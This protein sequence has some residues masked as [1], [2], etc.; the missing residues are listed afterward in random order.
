MAQQKS[1]R[2]VIDDLRG[3]QNSYDPPT[4]L[5]DNECVGANNV[6]WRGGKSL[7]KKRAGSAVSGFTAGHGTVP[8]RW[9][10]RHVPAGDETAAELWKLGIGYGDTV[11]LDRLVASTAYAAITMVDNW[12]TDP[13][14]LSAA[15]ACTFNG[16]LFLAGNTDVNYLH[17]WDGTSY[18]RVGITVPAA[19]TAADGAAMTRAATTIYYKVIYTVQ[20]AGVTLRR[21]KLSAALTHLNTVDKKTTVTKPA[22]TNPAC[23]ETHWELYASLDDASYSLVTAAIAVGTTTY[24]DEAVT[25]SG[26]GPPAVGANTPPPS[27][28]YLIVHN[29]RL[30]MAGA[31]E[32][33]GGE[34]TPKYNR[35]WYTPVLGSS[36]VGDDERVPIDNY[37]DLNEKSGAYPTGIAALFGDVYVF[38]S[39]SIWGLHATGD[40]DAPFQARQV[41]ATTAAASGI[42]C[43]NHRGIVAAEDETG[44][45]AIYFPSKRGIYRLGVGGLQYIGRN[46]ENSW[47]G[48]KLDDSLSPFSHGLY[49]PAANQIWWWSGET[50]T[51]TIWVYNIELG[52]WST[53]SGAIA[54]AT[55]SCLFSNTAGATMSRDLKPYIAGGYSASL[56]DTTVKCDTGTT[57]A[58]DTA[59]TT[60]ITATITLKPYALGNVEYL[61]SVS[62]PIL[63]MT[64]GAGITPRVLYKPNYGGQSDVSDTASAVAVGSETRARIVFDGLQTA[65]V[66][67]IQPIL[68]NTDTTGIGWT[69]DRLIIRYTPEE[70]AP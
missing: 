32:T 37:L 62:N 59:G 13:A 54:Y 64:T 61:F 66:Y 57:D 39:E 35:V 21:S 23:G 14:T 4:A 27:C 2:L 24:T 16:K 12:N 36:D 65:G 51:P 5:A 40:V 31:W 9:L 28:K 56:G 11:L 29:N 20:S 47:A 67:A 15:D 18:R 17:C 60:A 1:Y 46:I 41:S 63:V 69:M 70:A 26:A 38:T 42:G 33:T 44:Q 8:A 68:S 50:T 53:F 10:F 49:Y 48:V 22:A 3:G 19:P 30:V 25:Y 7:G 58:Q 6:D 34:T 43:I 45:P 52:A 55:A